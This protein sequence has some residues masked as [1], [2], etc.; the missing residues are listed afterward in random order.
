MRAA[1]AGVLL[2]SSVLLGGCALFGPGRSA[3]VPANPEL[4]QSRSLIEQASK[5]ATIQTHFRAELDRARASLEQALM[6]WNEERG[7][8]D[9]DDDEWHEMRHLNHMAR[10]RTA[11]IVMQARGLDAQYALN[12]LQSERERMLLTESHKQAAARSAAANRPAIGLPKALQQLRPRQESRGL[13][14][15][16][17][18]RLFEDGKGKLVADDAV[19][20]ALLQYLVANPAVVVSCEGHTGGGLAKEGAQRLSQERARA[21]QDALLERGLELSRVSAVGYGNSRPLAVNGD[22]RSNE[23]VEIVLSESAPVEF[24]SVVGD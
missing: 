13:V 21:V 2:L 17:G 18:A 10:Q 6:I 23:R 1:S 9:E 3:E 22:E 16:L 8:L 5:N 19:F 11:L 15:T 20:D 14:L 7:R 12:E 24:D 4:E